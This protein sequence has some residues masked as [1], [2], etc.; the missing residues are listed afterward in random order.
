LY[1]SDFILLINRQNKLTIWLTRYQRELE[2]L[3]IKEKV[4]LNL[5]PLNNTIK[6]TKRI[7]KCLEYFSNR[8][9]FSNADIIIRCSTD[10]CW[11]DNFNGSYV[12]LPMVDYE[13]LLFYFS[14]SAYDLP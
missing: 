6:G 5:L 13:S 3:A 9:Q 1:R 11:L 7:A 14:N 4:Y 2:L 12:F 10:C 8:Y